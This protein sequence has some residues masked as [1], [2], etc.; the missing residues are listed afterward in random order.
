[1][2]DQ[3]VEWTEWVQKTGGEGGVLGPA[4]LGLLVMIFYGLWVGIIRSQLHKI[5]D[6]LVTESVRRSSAG[7]GPPQT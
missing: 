6:P 5:A 1:M 7:S 3:F 2:M 4:A